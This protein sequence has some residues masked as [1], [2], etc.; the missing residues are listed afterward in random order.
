MAIA[1]SKF[2]QLHYQNE[3]SM[4]FEKCME[5][6]M[7]CFNTLHKDPDQCYFDRQNVEKLLKVI[8]CQDAAKA[9]IEKQE[10]RYLRN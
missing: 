3:R 9:V 5:I 2:D 8:K 4:S 10:V 6:M 7:K 1:K